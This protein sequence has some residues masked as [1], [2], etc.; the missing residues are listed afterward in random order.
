MHNPRASKQVPQSGGTGAAAE[1]VG[2]SL[3]L[4]KFA[5][6]RQRTRGPGDTKQE[7]KAP[8]EE[9][10]MGDIQVVQRKPLFFNKDASHPGVTAKG[11]QG[12]W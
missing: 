10:D 4:Y 11:G 2:S 8:L 3:D 7:T 6:H 5:V 12:H 1:L 9:R